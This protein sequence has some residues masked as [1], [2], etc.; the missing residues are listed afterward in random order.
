[1]TH[2]IYHRPF[3]CVLR[4]MSL[5]MAAAMLPA[6]TRPMARHARAITVQWTSATRWRHDLRK[7]WGSLSISEAG[8]RFQPA[9]GPALDWRFEEIQTFDL[10][11]RNLRLTGYQNRQW[12]FYGERSF[13]FELSSAMPPEVAAEM[14][15]RVGKPSEN[16]I[17]DPD[18]PV[19]ATLP[20]RH[21]TRVGGTN[22]VLRFRNSGIDYVTSS[23]AG[24]RSWRWADIETVAYPDPY[25]FR[26]AAYREIFNFEL[27]APMSAGLFD[28]VWNDVYAR[29]LKGLTV[30][31]GTRL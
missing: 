31:G 16:G 18:A 27:K 6:M 29:G 23:G 14:A 30:N 26:V 9:S 13:S 11:P 24:G 1:M 5:V 15:W 21:R 22:G 19:F 25:H 17:P 7:T 4:V 8:V 3:D 2:T 28:R 20:A 10:T 12:H